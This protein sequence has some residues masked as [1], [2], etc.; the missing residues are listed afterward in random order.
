MIQQMPGWIQPLHL[1]DVACNNDGY[2]GFLKPADCTLFGNH[3]HTPRIAG[4]LNQRCMAPQLLFLWAQDAERSENFLA[5]ARVGT[6]QINKLGTACVFS[7]LFLCIYFYQI[8]LC[9][10]F[11]YGLNIPKT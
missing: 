4:N 3:A 1:R 11:Y 6:S 8:V 5:K 7:F 2:K 9:K 10:S